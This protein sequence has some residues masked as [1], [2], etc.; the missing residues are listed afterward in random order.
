M[1]GFSPLSM[2]CLV[3]YIDAVIVIFMATEAG[4][5]PIEMAVAGAGAFILGKAFAEM[6]K[7]EGRV[8]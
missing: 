4:R 6:D 2:L 5:S 8:L 1:A 3:G 7:R